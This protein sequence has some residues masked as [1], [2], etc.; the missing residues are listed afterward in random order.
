MMIVG[1]D[2]GLNGAIAIIEPDTREITIFD[3]PTLSIKSKTKNKNEYDIQKMVEILSD[4]AGVI[5]AVYLE[6]VHSMPGQG[7]ASMFSMGYGYGLW[8]GILAAL[9]IPYNL[10]IPQQWKKK[11]LA[12]MTSEEKQNK[13]TSIIRA[14]QLY[15]DAKIFGVKGGGKDGR[16]EALLIAT[17]GMYD[18]GYENKLS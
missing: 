15:P 14:Q 1:I 17:Y 7:V 18:V 4:N 9:K 11:M 16:A 10:V 3:T 5:R 2:P 12:G 8:I 6:K 13:K